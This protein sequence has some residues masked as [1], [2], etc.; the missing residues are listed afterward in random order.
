MQNVLAY[1][2]CPILRRTRAAGSGAETA[3]RL[4]VVM[5]KGWDELLGVEL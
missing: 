1:F 4:R 5:G 3:E 2:R